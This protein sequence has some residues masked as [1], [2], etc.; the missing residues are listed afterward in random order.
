MFIVNNKRHYINLLEDKYRVRINFEIEEVPSVDNYSLD[1][2]PRENNKNTSKKHLPTMHEEE[3][4]IGDLDSYQDAEEKQNIKA[5]DDSTDDETQMF[6]INKMSHNKRNNNRRMK[7][8]HGN[9]HQNSTH[10]NNRRRKKKYEDESAAKKK[11]VK[12]EG[13]WWQKIFG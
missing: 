12:K 1:I 2:T 9:N 5:C 11:N 10:G 4:E 6:K 7:P 8:S 3:I 13:G